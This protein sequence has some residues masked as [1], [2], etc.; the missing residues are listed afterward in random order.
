MNFKEIA[1]SLASGCLVYALALACSSAGTDHGGGTENTGG[2][3]GMNGNG[4][5]SSGAATGTGAVAMAA[6]GGDSTG[7][8]DCPEPEPDVMFERDCTVGASVGTTKFAQLTI[9]GATLTDLVRVRAV[10]LL[11][12]ATA[13]PNGT[14][15][16]ANTL[17][18]SNSSVAIA[19]SSS[20]TEKATFFV[21]ADLADKVE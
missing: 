17:T 7:T 10:Y 19:C 4:G 18:Y 2:I 9:T 13:W 14:T 3:S 21:P 20:T 8:C 6:T 16:L 11:E 1:K 12:T 5:S 15:A